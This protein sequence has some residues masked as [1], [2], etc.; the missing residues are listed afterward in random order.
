MSQITR[1]RALPHRHIA[2]FSLSHMFE[3]AR[4]RRQLARL[5]DA[6]L[7]D[8]GLTRHQAHREASRAF[9]DIDA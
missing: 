4:Q 7:T 1:T 9:W 6:A 8:M 5:D 2:R 3:I